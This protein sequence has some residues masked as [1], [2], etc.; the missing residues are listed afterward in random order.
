MLSLCFFSIMVNA[1][2]KAS[3]LKF[4]S[5]NS[6]GLLN[7]ESQSTFTM[8]TVNGIKYKSWFTGLGVSLDN[9]G[10]RSIPV[11]VDVKKCFV[12]KEWQPFIYADAGIN[13]P[14]SS[15]ALPKKQNGL[16]AYKLY[17]TFYIGTGIGVSKSINNKARFVLSVGYS[18]KHFSYLHY[19]S[20]YYTP[21]VIYSYMQAAS[22]NISKYDFYYRRFSIK[23]GLEF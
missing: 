23:M 6:I 22:Y 13:F 2:Q 3:T 7:G 14:L 11:F 15:N 20:Y 10:Y 12:S 19:N 1:Q 8:Q 4:S 16:D 5:I 17:N 9:Y 21:T 18:F